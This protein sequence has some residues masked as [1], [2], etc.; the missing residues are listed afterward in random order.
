MSINDNAIMAH[1][2]LRP[3]LAR[4]RACWIPGHAGFLRDLMRRYSG[5]RP[6]C[7]LAQLSGGNQK[8]HRAGSSHDTGFVLL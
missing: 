8:G 7:A 4:W 3:V 5:A 2:R 6:R 1:H